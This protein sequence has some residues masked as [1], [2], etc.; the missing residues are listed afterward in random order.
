M[1]SSRELN[2]K[3]EF[4]LLCNPTENGW[5]QNKKVGREV[6]KSHEMIQEVGAIP[7]CVSPRPLLLKIRSPT[8]AP[9][10]LALLVQGPDDHEMGEEQITATDY[11]ISDAPFRL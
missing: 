10:A 11:K 7:G 4:H 6:N 9:R 3:Y 8:E 5:R 2:R 1:T